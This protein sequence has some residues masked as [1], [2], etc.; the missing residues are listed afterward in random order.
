M[1]EIKLPSHIVP[2]PKRK[3]FCRKIRETENEVQRLK[4]EGD[5]KKSAHLQ[6]VLRKAW[7]GYKRYRN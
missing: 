2:Y 5:W 6:W 7:W 1:N 4:D 3:K